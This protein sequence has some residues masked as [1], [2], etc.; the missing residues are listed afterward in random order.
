MEKIDLNSSPSSILSATIGSVF[1]LDDAEFVLEGD[2]LVFLTLV[3]SEEEEEY[4]TSSGYK[5]WAHVRNKAGYALM[6]RQEMCDMIE[7]GNYFI[8]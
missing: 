5:R 2:N 3:D 4:N 1:I 6:T 8:E 7:S